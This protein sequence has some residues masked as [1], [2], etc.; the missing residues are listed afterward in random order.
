MGRLRTPDENAL[1]IT[2]RE[3]PADTNT[4]PAVDMH[5]VDVVPYIG[6]GIYAMREKKFNSV[7]LQSAYTAAIGLWNFGWFASNFVMPFVAKYM[8]EQLQL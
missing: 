7:P 8:I 5:L 1:E 2:S 6:A 3:T 4:T